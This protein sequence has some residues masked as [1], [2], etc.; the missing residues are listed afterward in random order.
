MS[1]YQVK[2][3]VPLGIDDVMMVCK[4]AVASTGWRVTEAGNVRLKCKE[5]SV[6]STSFT[7]PAEVM[8]ELTTHETGTIIT[9]NGSI[10]GFG[11]IQSGHLEGQVGNLRNRIEVGLNKMIESK[12]QD[13][14]S[15]QQGSS[16]ISELERL[17]NLH[18]KGALTDDEFQQ[19]KK[20]VLMSSL[21]NEPANKSTERLE[22]QANSIVSPKSEP[23]AIETSKN[24]LCPNCNSPMQIRIATKGEHQGKQFYVCSNYP[25]CRGVLP[26]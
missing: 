9:M 13:Q 1:T 3:T 14:F 11:P 4:E 10:F 17:A 24:P 26:S 12:K 7:W 22:Q 19:A 6:Q 21:E 15:H 5:V 8:I 23:S 20:I 18:E 2:F 16:L 25:D